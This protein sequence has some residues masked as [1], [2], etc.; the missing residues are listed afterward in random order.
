MQRVFVEYDAMMAEV[1]VNVS[2][3]S[4]MQ[5]LSRNY[6]LQFCLYWISQSFHNLL[7]YTKDVL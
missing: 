1:Q 7:Q 4:Y 5:A 6:I 2:D 3:F